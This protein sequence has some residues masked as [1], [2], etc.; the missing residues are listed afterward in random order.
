MENDNGRG[1]II[2]MRH[3][4]ILPLALL[5]CIILTSC[6]SG[7]LDR[8]ALGWEEDWTAVGEIVASEQVAGFEPSENLDAMSASGLWYATWTS[9]EMEV[10][11]NDEGQRSEIYDAQIYLLIQEFKS[12]PKAL[13]ELE[14]WKNRER[15]SYACGDTVTGTYADVSFEILPLLE[16][17]ETNPYSHGAAAFGCFGN[18]SVCA[19]LMCREEFAGDALEI[20]E[21]FLSGLHFNGGEAE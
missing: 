15:D 18:C 6:A 13:A 19:E 14:V 11:E 9:G 10:R 3:R 21:G 17:A 1:C 4:R 20:M 5:I 2:P 16:G 8:A 12:G 7:E